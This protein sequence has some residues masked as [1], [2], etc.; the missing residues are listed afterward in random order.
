MECC[1]ES[2]NDKHVYA[3]LPIYL[4][5]VEGT[6]YEHTSPDV[7]ESNHSPKH[8]IHR[9]NDGYS[10]CEHVLNIKRTAVSQ[11]SRKIVD[12]CLRLQEKEKGV[13]FLWS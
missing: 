13:R 9:T 5:G 3:A 11:I 6:H 10:V 12:V 8:E 1:I 4:T 7:I 2:S